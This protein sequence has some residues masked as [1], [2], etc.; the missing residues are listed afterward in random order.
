M[1]STRGFTDWHVTRGQIWRECVRIIKNYDSY[2]SSNLLI[3]SIYRGENYNQFLKRIT[4]N[5][6]PIDWKS[7]NV[8]YLL[9]VRQLQFV[10]VVEMFFLGSI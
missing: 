5:T 3:S 2:F 10:I 7:I 9:K 4:K 6:E 1:Y 8:S